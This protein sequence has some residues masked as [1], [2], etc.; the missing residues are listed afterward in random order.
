MTHPV[1]YQKAKTRARFNYINPLFYVRHIKNNLSGVGRRR[2]A[3]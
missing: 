2:R 1:G 3:V